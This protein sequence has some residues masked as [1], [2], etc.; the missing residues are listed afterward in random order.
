MLITFLSYTTFSLSCASETL[1]ENI[2]SFFERTLSM[3]LAQDA[4]VIPSTLKDA[5]SLF[6]FTSSGV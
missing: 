3:F 4:Q 5:S 2:P 6:L 1:A